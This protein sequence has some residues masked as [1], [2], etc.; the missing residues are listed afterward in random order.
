MKGKRIKVFLVNTIILILSSLV[1]RA[2]G[3]GFGVYIS[4]RIDKE[5][6]GIFQ[7]IMSVYMFGV[8]LATSGINLAST[9][10][11]SEELTVSN[12]YGAKKA[13]KKCISFSLICGILASLFIFINS[14]F[15]V[16]ICL[17]NKVDVWVIY[18][19]CIAL[20]FI[21]MSASINGY[22][23]AIRK[24]YK[25]ISSQFFEQFIKILI[26]AYLINLFFPKGLNYICVS[27]ILG[28][29]ISEIAS[30]IY[31]YILYIFD[32][33]IYRTVANRQSPINNKRI[34]RISVPV[35]L[36]SYIR[37][38]L[39]TLKQI[40]I[41]S[42]LERS[43]L[44]CSQALSQY[45]II[46]GMAM[47]IISFAGLFINSFSG[48]LVPEFSR[49]YIKKDYKRIKEVTTFILFITSLISITITILIFCF[50]SQISNLIYHDIQIAIYL[51]LLA[52]L[53]LFM[54]T[55]TVI[56]S[57]L[58]GLDAQ[59]SVMIIN[60][61]DLIISLTIIYFVVPIL[62]LLG[63]ILSLFISELL[64]FI[65]SSFK[66]YRIIRKNM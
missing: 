56:D 29:V 38:G 10:I 55:D 42:S 36:T 61:I 5:T 48:L 47:P 54:Y 46:T 44:E 39:S 9:R 30:F 37:S 19:I 43:G 6:L 60:I 12:E 24:V 35:A 25:T 15:I 23:T 4:N 32:K 34:L 51:K 8:T 7:L 59:T 33:R 20:P 17:H 66:L 62:G 16:Q 40:M 65:L 14:N 1:L 53:M 45:G 13:A 58:K 26:S 11:V 2:I 64:N 3:M 52:P 41:P 28:D 63:Y 57:I 31:L 18:L 50:A 27:L 49:Y 22:F 21:S